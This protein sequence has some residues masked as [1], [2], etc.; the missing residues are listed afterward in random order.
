MGEYVWTN[1]PDVSVLTAYSCILAGG[2]HV[3]VMKRAL[4][5][6]MVCAFKFDS[7]ESLYVEK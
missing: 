7:S 3:H 5:H 6:H 1:S 4:S 2:I